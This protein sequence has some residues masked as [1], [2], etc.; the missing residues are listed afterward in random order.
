MAPRVIADD[1][2]QIVL[3]VTPNAS[4]GARVLYGTRTKPFVMTADAGA[5]PDIAFVQLNGLEAPAALVLLWMAPDPPF[6][7]TR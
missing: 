3:P 5:R 4:D 6:A 7:S 2:E 1:G